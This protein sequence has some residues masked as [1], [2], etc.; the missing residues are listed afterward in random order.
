MSEPTVSV[1]IPTYNRAG[2]V[3]A[4]IMSALEQPDT[5]D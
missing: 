3:A 1:V 4:S 5:P 2:T